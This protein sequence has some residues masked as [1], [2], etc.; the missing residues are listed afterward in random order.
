MQIPCF[1]RQQ[2]CCEEQEELLSSAWLCPTCCIPSEVQ[3]TAWSEGGD[4]LA[5]LRAEIW[6]AFSSR[7]RETPL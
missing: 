7:P 3:R 5:V 6:N 1:K 4:Q 2:C